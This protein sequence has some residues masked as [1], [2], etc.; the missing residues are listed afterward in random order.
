MPEKH[1]VKENK[2][3]IQK[4]KSRNGKHLKLLPFKTE[5]TSYFQS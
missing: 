1:I 3:K 2:I 4:Q 5:K